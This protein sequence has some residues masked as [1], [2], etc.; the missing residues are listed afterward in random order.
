[1]LNQLITLDNL[2]LRDALTDQGGGDPDEEEGWVT[3]LG[4]G[5]DLEQEDRDLEDGAEG[6][7][8][9]EESEEKAGDDEDETLASTKDKLSF[10]SQRHQKV[11]ELLGDEYP[12]VADNIRS[13][14]KGET[15]NVQAPVTPPQ[16]KTDETN[17]D[18]AQ[19]TDLTQQQ[20]GDYIS[21]T[22][23]SAVAETVKQMQQTAQTEAELDLVFRELNTLAGDFN[24][25]KDEVQA[26]LTEVNKLGINPKT[27]GKT[28]SFG[29]AVSQAF[30]N[31]ALRN[32]MKG[33]ARGAAADAEDAQ[34]KATLTRVPGR[35][36]AKPGAKKS[37]EEIALE[38]MRQVGPRGSRSVLD[39]ERNATKR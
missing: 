34:R 11:M 13:Q 36:V 7:D 22:V 10:I 15:K 8:E 1:M 18:H 3:E 2:R 28:R 33:T 39:S 37:N 21:K 19:L 23:T 31:I 5:D 9:D 30:Q 4:D 35:Q 16:A 38:R 20:L 29:L 14:L 12:D 25:T 17:N 24:L 6:S 32:A 26:A 27:P